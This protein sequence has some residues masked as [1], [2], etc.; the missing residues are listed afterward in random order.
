[1]TTASMERLHAKK[2]ELFVGTARLFLKAFEN[3]DRKG[4]LLVV[5]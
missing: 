2:P 1:M 4:C 5:H 3:D